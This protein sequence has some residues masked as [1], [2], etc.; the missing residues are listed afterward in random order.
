MNRK[1]GWKP[2]ALD[3]R[4][5]PWRGGL[6]A[7][8]L[9][10]AIDLRLLAKWPEAYDQLELGSCTANAIAAA[11]AWESLKVGKS[12]PMFSRLFIY[13]NE[14][15]LEHTVKSDAGAMIR[16]GVKSV[17]KIGCCLE[18]SWKYIPA[19]FAQ[20]PPP[21]AYASATHHKAIGYRRVAVDLTAI[22]SALAA[23]YPVIVGLSVYDSFES[24][25]VAT[26]GRVPMPNI[27]TEPLLGGHAVLLVGY[28]D[29]AKRFI[30]RNSWGPGWG[31]GGYFTIPYAYVG[32]PKLGD[33]Y[34]VLQP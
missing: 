28:D 13:F 24:E 14:R 21:R 8:R 29:K 4:D 5:I 32:D 19:K 34:W 22:R 25:K 10:E 31:K 7:A 20:K 30:G 15:T 18:A 9:P 27:R 26:T 3:A 1:Y 23:R 17:S 2:D 16:D 6:R 11:L 12:A 33:D